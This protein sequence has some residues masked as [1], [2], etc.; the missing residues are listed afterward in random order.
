MKG[1]YKILNTIN[2]KY[3]I[4][5]S[6][7][8]ENRWIKHKKKL[9][10]NRHRNVLL[11]NNWNK[12]GPESFKLLI[13]EEVENVNN[14]LNR[15]QYYLDKLFKE[16]CDNIL[17]IGRQA[18]GGDKVTNNPRADS[19]SRGSTLNRRIAGKIRGEN[20]KGHKSHFYNKHHT[21]E[22]KNQISKKLKGRIPVNRKPTC[23][24]GINYVSILEASIKLN[25][26]IRKLY[27]MIKSSNIKYKEYQ[28][29]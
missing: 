22:T 11:Q 23:I 1:I 7:N 17:N 18:E 9:K 4:G 28:L 5:S 8:I 27:Y 13:I 12:Y 20:M 24:N 29:I 19:K 16:D 14:I 6:K 3:Y 21:T 10:S 25:I 15:E 26:P 2:N